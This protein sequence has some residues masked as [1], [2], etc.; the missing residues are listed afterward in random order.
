MKNHSTNTPSQSDAMETRPVSGFVR[1]MEAS[2]FDRMFRREASPQ[3]LRT[4]SEAAEPVS[5]SAEPPKAK[6]AAA[7]AQR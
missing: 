5:I 1:F 2:F 3:Q 6:G 4:A 7:G